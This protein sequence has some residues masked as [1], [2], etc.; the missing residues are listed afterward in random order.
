[1]QAKLWHILFFLVFAIAAL[2]SYL[3]LSD[4]A[5]EPSKAIT[6]KTK[7]IL[8][9]EILPEQELIPEPIKKAFTNDVLGVKLCPLML[10]LGY[11]VDHKGT[12]T[13]IDDE[14]YI[15][16]GNNK[17]MAEQVYLE[18]DDTPESGLELAALGSSKI[19]S[20]LITSWWRSRRIS[21]NK[22]FNLLI[23]P[24]SCPKISS[25][26]IISFPLEEEAYLD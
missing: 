26:L 21:E 22:T 20:N 11:F 5:I 17:A 25:E 23:K 2:Y 24:K 18:I 3:I 9:Q 19:K 10:D 16:I 14:I 15:G 1:M 12:M 6:E 8:Q 13:P 4:N 7:P